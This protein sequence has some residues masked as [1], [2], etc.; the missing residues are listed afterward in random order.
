M[1]F[2]GPSFSAPSFAAHDK[3]CVSESVVMNDA[4]LSPPKSQPR[5]RRIIMWALRLLT[6]S[7]LV[8]CGKQ[9]GERVFHWLHLIFGRMAEAIPNRIYEKR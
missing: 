7:F 2:S 8:E 1:S 3:L 4:Q 6:W 9:C 5:E